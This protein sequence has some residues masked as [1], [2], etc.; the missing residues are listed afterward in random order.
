MKILECVVAIRA[1]LV[2]AGFDL[3]GSQVFLQAQ[4]EGSQVGG[5]RE[6]VEPGLHRFAEPLRHPNSLQKTFAVH[7]GG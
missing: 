4:A 2:I 5:Q 1:A 3:G 7:S 6:R